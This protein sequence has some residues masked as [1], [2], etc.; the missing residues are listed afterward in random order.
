MAR[1]VLG[2]AT[3]HGPMLSTPPERW[4]DRVEADRAR[5]HPFRGEEYSFDEL[6]RLRS[7]EG[8]AAQ[9]AL[10]ERRKRL[11]RCRRAIDV[12]ARAFDEARPDAAVIVG[13][14]QH[15]LFLER[16]M[17]AFALYWGET[18][19][20]VPSTPEQIAKQAPGIA[21]AERGH[22]PE[23]GAVYPG[24][25]ELGRHLIESLVQDEFDV[26]Q[27]TALPK[28]SDWSSGI[29]HAYGFVYRQILK[30]DVIPNVPVF[31]NTFY[32]PNQPT[33]SRCYR[34]GRALGRAIAAFRPDQRIALIASG[35]L[36]HFVID[37][38]FDREV[39]T[40]MQSKG[41]ERMNALPA[42]RFRS[43]T[44]EVKN[45][46]PVAAALA[47]TGLEMTVVDYVPCYRSEA[48]TGNAMGFAFWR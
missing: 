17:P 30:D 24:F 4:G 26:A 9:S 25:P 45:W 46:I 10:E 40:S 34:F 6:V 38:D 28:G 35:G 29:P 39:L 47:D 5:R 31:V 8:L 23:E 48:G 33:V 14:D 11:E 36:S 20:N 37:E 16:N 7:S 15:E 18:I 21:I 19:E 41:E 44:S 12:L 2:L 27:M 22:C 3:S 42:D 32:P 43:G 1:I 13:N